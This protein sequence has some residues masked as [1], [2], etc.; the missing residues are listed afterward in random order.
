MIRLPQI[1]GDTWF[2]TKPLTT[3]DLKGKVVLVDF[4]TYSCINCL[5]T[6]PYLRKW[7]DKYK[8]KRFLLIGVHTPEFEFE[9]DPKNVEKAIKELEIKWPIVMDNDYV[10]WNNFS[11][12]YWPAKYLADKEGN[13]V[14]THFG[15]GG[16]AETEGKIQQLIKQNSVDTEF[17]E[18]RAEEHS[19]GRVC[20]T[21]TPEL[22]C[23]YKRG[24]LANE[25]SYKP[26]E[27]AEYKKPK[28]ILGNSIALSGSFLAKS[29]Y[30]ESVKEKAELLLHFRATEV[31]LVLSPVGKHS[32]VE[33][34]LD[35]KPLA[36]KIQGKDIVNSGKV[37]IEKPRMYNLLKSNNMVE[38]IL[39]ISS[40]KGGNFRAFA[41]TFSGCSE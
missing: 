3:D 25:E 24:Y 36:K 30:I 13:I 33:I 17:P 20:F 16:Y 12:Q 11:N 1:I 35:D 26:E 41:F 29:E 37:D 15:E 34:K 5:R 19:H 22:Y 10:N 38:G 4:W 8:D 32:I 7:W 27:K 23:G 14:Y 28:L 39:S 21:P 18:I 2:L 40:L 31:N 6:L 9:K